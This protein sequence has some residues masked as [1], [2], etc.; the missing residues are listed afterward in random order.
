MRGLAPRHL[1]AVT[2]SFFVHAP[3]RPQ[4]TPH[5][6][7]RGKKYIKKM[8]KFMRL[9][10]QKG[11]PRGIRVKFVR[12]LIIKAVSITDEEHVKQLTAC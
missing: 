6:G 1:R 5:M 9:Y 7:L 8:C 10:S 12:L 4:T 11:E 3:N 2:L